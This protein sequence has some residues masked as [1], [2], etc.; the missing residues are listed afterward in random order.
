MSQLQ[1]CNFSIMFVLNRAEF[2]FFLLDL[3]N[4]IN[5]TINDVLIL[6]NSL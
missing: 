6:V 5:I 1:G 4:I 2:L 3:F